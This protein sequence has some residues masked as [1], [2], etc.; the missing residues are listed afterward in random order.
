MD[1]MPE[2]LKFL[3]LIVNV[4]LS[5][6][7]CI[8]YTLFCIWEN[9]KGYKWIWVALVIVGISWFVLYASDLFLLE[10]SIRSLMGSGLVRSAITLTLG[11][12]YAVSLQFRIPRRK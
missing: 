6:A 12:M 7:M 4:A 8:T 1:S 11:T 10:S 2:S 9:R 3:L 5:A